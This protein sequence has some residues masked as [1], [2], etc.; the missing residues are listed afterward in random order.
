M[1]ASSKALGI[2]SKDI[3]SK[4][5]P[6]R[7]PKHDLNKDDTT[8]HANLHGVGRLMILSLSKLEVSPELLV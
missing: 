4:V 1:S 6:T 8:R 5:S 3:K 7:L 2:K